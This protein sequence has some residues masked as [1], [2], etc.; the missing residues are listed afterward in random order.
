MPCI[1]TVSNFIRCIYFSTSLI[2]KSSV[3][4]DITVCGLM[5]INQRFGGTCRLD[6]QGRRIKQARTQK[7]ACSKQ[8]LIHAGFL[9]DLLFRPGDGDDIFLRNVSWLSPAC[10]VLCPRRLTLHNHRYE[11]LNSCKFYI[12]CPSRVFYSFIRG[13]ESSLSPTREL[14]MWRW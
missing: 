1:H 9:H 4:W 13:H 8:S 11:K 7:E 5:K 6:H 12:A 2:L 10:S 3:F 14:K